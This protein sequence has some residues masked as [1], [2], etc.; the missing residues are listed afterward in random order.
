M[1]TSA[2]GADRRR[3]RQAGFTLVELMVVTAIV[4]LMAGIAVLT[5]PREGRSLSSEAEQFAARLVRAKEEAL[6]TNRSVAV[7]VTNDGYAFHA[8]G[9]AGWAP[10]H[11]GPFK[12]TIWGEGVAV[13]PEQGGGRAEVRFEATGQTEP[14]SIVLSRAQRR[15]RVSVDGA[16]NV[17]IDAP[18]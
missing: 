7:R 12:P 11:D 5:A 16:G 14:F 9:R 1:P 2:T 15:V 17:R 8:R 4:G 10:L 3:S 6:L 18:G 13:A